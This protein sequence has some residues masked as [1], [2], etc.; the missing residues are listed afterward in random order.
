MRRILPVAALAALLL[1]LAGC[2]GGEE[3]GAFPETV[4]GTVKEQPAAGGGA[5]K[6]LFISQGCGGCHTFKAAG[7]AG[8]VGPDLDQVVADAQKAGKSV[9]DYIR[10]SILN[11]DAY[12]AP[13]FAKGIMPPFE[14]KLTDS[15][16]DELISFLSGSGS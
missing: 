13:G 16:V 14:G 6:A 1:A 8:T 11:P 10:E 4:V 9:E 2:G 7:T 15:Q 3:V 12:V 5:G